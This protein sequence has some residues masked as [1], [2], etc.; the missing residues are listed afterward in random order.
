VLRDVDDTIPQRS[1]TTQQQ[2]ELS[3]I[4]QNCSAVLKKL[5]E[6]LN[7]NQ[8]LESDVKGLNARSIRVWR[9]LQWDQKEIDLFRSQIN[10]KI[11]AFDL[12][13]GGITR[14][15]GISRIA[16]HH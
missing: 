11:T 1:L 13:L 2:K 16:Q 12:F 6:T 7:K 15:Q 10:L 4:A 9:R 3:K 5:E 14:Y 8:I